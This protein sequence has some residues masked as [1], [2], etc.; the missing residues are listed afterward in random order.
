MVAEL[1]MA[2]MVGHDVPHDGQ[3]QPQPLRPRLPAVRQAGVG[4]TQLVQRLLGHAGAVVAHRQQDLTL[5]AVLHA[6]LHRPT[7]AAAAVEHR[8][9]QQ[10]APGLS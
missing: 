2:A 3:A 9:V 6:Q 5:R 8:V 7:L 10:I 4:L 1:Q